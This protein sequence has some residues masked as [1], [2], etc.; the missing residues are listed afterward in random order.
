[1]EENL[2]QC[3]KKKLIVFLKYNNV[4]FQKTFSFID[5]D[6]ISH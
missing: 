1:M 2:D 6:I 3:E 5:D 4:V